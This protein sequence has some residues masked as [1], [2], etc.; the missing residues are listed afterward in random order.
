MRVGADYHFMQISNGSDGSAFWQFKAGKTGPVMRLRGNYTP[1]TASWDLYSYNILYGYIVDQANFY[2]DS[3][4]YYM[5]IE[6]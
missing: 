5:I 2:N 1:S 3:G 4:I 6:D